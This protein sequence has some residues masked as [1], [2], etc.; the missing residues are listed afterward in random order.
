MASLQP[1][2]V[3][4]A[5]C[6]LEGTRFVAMD[7]GEEHEFAFNEGISLIVDA[8]EQQEIDYYW[9]RLSADPDSE[10]CGWLKDRFGVSWQV[11]PVAESNRMLLNRDR[12]AA[13]R[14]MEAMFAMKKIDIRALRRAAEG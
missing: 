2:W 10:Q 14:V 7:G 3:M 1:D 5:E 8:A 6:T 4:Y 11:V 13:E 12:A 9:S